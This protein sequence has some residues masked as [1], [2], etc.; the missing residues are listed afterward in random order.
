[1]W[2]LLLLLRRG[3]DVTH[4]QAIDFGSENQKHEIEGPEGLR[5]LLEAMEMTRWVIR[6]RL[7]EIKTSA[8]A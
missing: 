3:S 8:R 6:I 7:R 2:A 4:L 1:M 5:T